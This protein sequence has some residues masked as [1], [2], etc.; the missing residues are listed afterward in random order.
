MS[1]IHKP[2]R[3]PELNLQPPITD[4]VRLSEDMQQT[5]ALLVAYSE[6][7]RVLIKASESG[8]LNTVNPRIKGIWGF[9]G[10][11]NNT[12]KQGDNI[13]CNE[14]MITAHPIN[15]GNLWVRPHSRYVP[16]GDGAN[17][18][19]PVGAGDV[20][21]FAVSNLNQIWFTFEQQEDKVIVAYT[22]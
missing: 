7:Q 16:S 6:N 4:K 5:L 15:V 17:F 2:M 21:N 18:A 20:V 8:V 19:W 22:I 9:E 10:L 1:N 14:V 3:M 13:T 11:G 12:W